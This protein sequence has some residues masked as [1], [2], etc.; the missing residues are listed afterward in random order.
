MLGTQVGVSVSTAPARACRACR[1][2]PGAASLPPARAPRRG[3]QPHLQTS[4]SVLPPAQQQGAGSGAPLPG[5]WASARSP[6]E[7][8]RLLLA[9]VK[10]PIYT[11]AIVPVLV[12][13]CAVVLLWAV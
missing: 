2:R 12:R 11:V 9:V 13:A 10:P 4:A 7:R 8:R 6:Q 3:R 5:S 1:Q